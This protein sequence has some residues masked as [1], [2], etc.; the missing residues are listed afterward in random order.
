MKFL[1][2]RNRLVTACIAAGLVLSVERISSEI[3][4]GAPIPPAPAF[5]SPRHQANRL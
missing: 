2:L 1:P 4:E 5:T 3:A